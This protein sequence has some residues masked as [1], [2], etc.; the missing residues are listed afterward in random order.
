MVI[1]TKNEEKNISSCLKNVDFCDEII[2][3]DDNSTDKTVEIAKKVGAKVFR[4]VLNEDFSAQR[5]FGLAKASSKWILFLDA[6]ERV[7]RELAEEINQLMNDSFVRIKGFF[8]RRLDFLWGRSLKH[9]EAGNTKLLR[10][11]LKTAGQWERRVHEKLVIAG[12]VKSLK[13]PIEHYPHQTLQEFIKHINFWS[14]LHAKANREEGKKSN[15]V[16]IILMPSVHFVKN[17]VF[18]FGFLDGTRGFVFALVMSFHSF[19]GWTK[20]WMMQKK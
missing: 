15:P 4:R 20:L 9:G 16:K 17:F 13:Y 6:D 19:L 12:R 3:I 1:L 5:N 2:V 8:I 14:D 11:T 18:K 7:S 10:L